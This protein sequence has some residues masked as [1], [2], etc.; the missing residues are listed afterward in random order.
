M[1]FR[2]LD[3]WQR[4]YQLALSVCKEVKSCKDYGLK[5]QISRSSVSV[6]SNI[7]E[8]AER[9]TA[10]DNIRFLYFAKGSCGEL[11]TQLML[12]RDLNYIPEQRADA[13]INESIEVSRMIGGLIK[14]RSSQI[15]EDCG[16]YEL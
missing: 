9:Q 15:K 11:L 6:P 1:H 12:A 3:V 7:A 4:S 2:K 5:D 8:G 16:E 13:L 10:K 14:Y